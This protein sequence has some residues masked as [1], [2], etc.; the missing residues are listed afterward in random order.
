[1]MRENSKRFILAHSS[2]LLKVSTLK[3]MGLKGEG[4]TSRDL[5]DSGVE[6]SGVSDEVSAFLSLLH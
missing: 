6:T 5:I 1:M 4:F 3:K 2:L